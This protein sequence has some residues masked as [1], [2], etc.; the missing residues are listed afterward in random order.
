MIDLFLNNGWLIVASVLVALFG[1]GRL[2]R[3]ITWDEYPPTIA[4]RA[5]WT[6]ITKPYPGWEK[7]FTC[8][9]CFTPWLMLGALGWFAVGLWVEWVAIAWWVF[10]GWLALSYATSIIMARDEPQD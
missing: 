3:I 8:F 4:L 7:L 10:W 6:R 5:W 1:V 2:S 9:W